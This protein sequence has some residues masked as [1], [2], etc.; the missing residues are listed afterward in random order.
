MMNVN[1]CRDCK[2]MRFLI[3]NNKCKSCVK[4]DIT[5]LEYS[6]IKQLVNNRTDAMGERSLNMKNSYD[7]IIDELENGVICENSPNNKYSLVKTN[8]VTSRY[9]SKTSKVKLIDEKTAN[10]IINL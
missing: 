3:S 5:D 1:K 6:V 10:Y 4:K 8:A 9:G 7:N 2:R